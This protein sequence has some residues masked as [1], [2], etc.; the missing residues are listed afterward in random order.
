MPAPEGDVTLGIA[1]VD[2]ARAR[3]SAASRCAS[4]RTTSS[5]RRA[6]GAEAELTVVFDELGDAEKI[7]RLPVTFARGGPPTLRFVL[8][9]KE[10]EKC[11]ALAA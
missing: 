3:P 7:V 1:Q 9:G 10:V 2:R 5:T 6:S 8:A 11:S 4:S